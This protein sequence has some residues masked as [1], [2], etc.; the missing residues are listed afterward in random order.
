MLAYRQALKL[1]GF[2]GTPLLFI[3]NYIYGEDY[4]PL[5]F[6]S[7]YIIFEAFERHS[8]VVYSFLVQ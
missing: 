6:N 3:W 2:I 5:I 1:F 4:L 7:G 8:Y